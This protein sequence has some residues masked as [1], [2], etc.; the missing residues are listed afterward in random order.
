MHFERSAVLRSGRPSGM[1]FSRILGMHSEQL[2]CMLSKRPPG[3][4]SERCLGMRRDWSSSVA[5]SVWRDGSACWLQIKICCR[6]SSVGPVTSLCVL[7]AVAEGETRVE[8]RPDPLGVGDG[9]I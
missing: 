2:A 3:M 7:G 9:N 6:R 8:S 1:H 4:H 5:V